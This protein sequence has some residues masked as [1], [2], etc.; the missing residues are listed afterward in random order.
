MA[1]LAVNNTGQINPRFANQ[2]AAKF[3]AELRVGNRI[4]QRRKRP[5]QRAANRAQIKSLVAG[6]IGDAKAATQINMCRSRARL[7]RNIR[8]QC[9]RCGLHFDNRKCEARANPRPPR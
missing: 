9:Q 7:V 3:D 6:E 8:R 2:I 1:H 5:L 4:G